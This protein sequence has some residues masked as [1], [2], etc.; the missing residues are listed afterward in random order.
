MFLPVP[1][2][3]DANSALYARDVADGFCLE[4]RDRRSFDRFVR[5]RARDLQHWRLPLQNIAKVWHPD[6]TIARQAMRL[7]ISKVNK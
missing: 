2:T 3:N 7:F 6:C 4:Q 5:E 1:P